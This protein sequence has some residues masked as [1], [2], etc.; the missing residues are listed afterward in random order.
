IATG[1]PQKPSDLVPGLPSGLSAIVL[2]AM[3]READKRYPDMES[4]VRALEPYAVPQAFR[5]ERREST[6]SGFRL[7]ATRIAPPH[8]PSSGHQGASMPRITSTPFAAEVAE[9]KRGFAW[10]S[11]PLLFVVAAIAV[12]AGVWYMTRES[13]VAPTQAALPPSTVDPGSIP[14]PSAAVVAPVVVAPAVVAAP[15]V[16]NPTLPPTAA[17][18]VDHATVREQ[19]PPPSA[20]GNGSAIAARP[21]ASHE[22]KQ[23]A[24]PIAHKHSARPATKAES[25]E[26][27]PTPPPARSRT[28]RSGTLNADEF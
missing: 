1:T 6:G 13:S 22:I 8:S 23:N 12:V 26:P 27:A 28:P 9:S 3:A 4:V 10:L 11:G 18:V 5:S 7:D 14:P 2:R 25:D 16:T 15:T 17:A 19:T 24:K 20:A 21:H